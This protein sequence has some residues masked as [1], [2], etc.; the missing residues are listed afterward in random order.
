M[1]RLFS[2]IAIPE[3]I[4]TELANLQTGLDG[5]R[6]INPHDF[7][8][9]LRFA[10]DID[11][12]QAEDFSQF[13]SRITFTPFEITLASMGSFGGKRP[14]AV[15][16]GMEKNESI[17]DLHHAHEMAA[18]HAGLKPESRKFIPHV[19]LARLRGTNT[20]DVARYLEQKGLVK[21]T[22]FTVNKNVLFSARP[23]GGG[24]PYKI[25]EIYPA[26]G[27]YSE[28]QLDKF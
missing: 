2:G 8:I 25:E 3:N 6:W 26:S 4:Q 24:G 15:W 16:I 20:Y 12:R 17:I 21:M 19:T 10:G 22:S 13:L 9:T 14:R 28:A 23:G 7:H 18:Q 1:P 11:G 27:D 5:V